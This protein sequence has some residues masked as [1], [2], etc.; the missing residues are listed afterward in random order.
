MAKKLILD[1]VEIHD[2]KSEDDYVV[3]NE[4]DFDERIHVEYAKDRPNRLCKVNATEEEIQAFLDGKKG[5]EQKPKPKAKKAPASKKAAA[6]T[7]E[8]DTV[9]R[10]S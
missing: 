10:V 4:D 1:T 9:E 3:I 5:S 8:D 6:E 7:T 2:P